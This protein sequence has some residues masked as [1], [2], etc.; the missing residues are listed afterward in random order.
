MQQPYLVSSLF[1]AVGGDNPLL[2]HLASVDYLILAVYFAFVIGI[3]W[4]LRK[5]L[6]T[7]TDFFESGRSLPAWVCALGFIGANLGAQEVIGMAASGAKYGIATAHFY[8]LGAIPAM[9]FVGIFMMP[10]YYGSKARSVP[11]YLKMRF[12]E[13]TRA[14]SSRSTEYDEVV[15]GIRPKSVGS[16]HRNAGGFSDC[17]KTRYYRI[18]VG[19]L[20]SQNLTMIV[21]GDTPHIVVNRRKYGNWR[22]GNIYARE[23]LCTLGNTWYA[24]FQYFRV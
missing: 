18:R 13:R 12:D 9:V 1:A 3:G 11:E 16:V 4:I 2:L 21:C 24:L 19:V 22:F 10:F 17:Q 6:K 23:N 5:Y 7:S 14:K 20:L 8:W 15:Q